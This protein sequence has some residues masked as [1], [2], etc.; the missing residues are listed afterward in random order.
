[1]PY[2]RYI[3]YLNLFG[4]TAC[5]RRNDNR[6]MDSQG[7]L[8]Q[9]PGTGNKNYYRYTCTTGGIYHSAC[10][11]NSGMRCSAFGTNSKQENLLLLHR[12]QP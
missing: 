4:S 5:L 10:R 9:R 7:C 11:C 2:H 3:G 1:M 6:N 12:M 8:R